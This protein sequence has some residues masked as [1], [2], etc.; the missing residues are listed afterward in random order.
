[1]DTFNTSV[2]GARMSSACRGGDTARAYMG[3]THDASVP[4]VQTLINPRHHGVRT[5]GVLFHEATIVA[6][7]RT[8]PTP[9]LLGVRRLPCR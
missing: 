6:D 5:Y 3:A 1:M 2:E 9:H 8:Q 4:P 7:G